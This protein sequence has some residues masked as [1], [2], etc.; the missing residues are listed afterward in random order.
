VS[1][2]TSA[3]GGLAILL[4]AVAAMSVVGLRLRS[5]LIPSAQGVLGWQL[6]AALGMLAQL[7]SAELLGLGGMLQR[8]PL[9]AVDLLLGAGALVA[10][11]LDVPRLGR[12][13]VP[14]KTVVVALGCMGVVAASW[15]L[16]VRAVAHTGI[17]AVDALDYHLVFA[18]D[19]IRSGHTAAIDYVSAGDPS[20]YYPANDELLRAVAIL[21]FGR[22]SLI[23][24][25]GLLLLPFVWGASWALGRKLGRPVEAVACSCVLLAVLGR[26]YAASAMN[27]WTGIWFLL[28]ALAVLLHDRRLGWRPLVVLGALTGLAAGTKFS[29]LAPAGV[30]ALLAVSRARSRFSSL[31]AVALGALAGGGFWYVRNWVQVGSPVPGVRALKALHLAGPEMPHLAALD[32]SVGSYLTSPH[33]MRQWFVPGLAHALGPAWW[34]IL[35]LAAGGAVVG[36]LRPAS[37][38]TRIAAALSLTWLLLYVVTPASAGG[39]VGRPVLFTFNLRFAY[40]GLLLG[41]VALT[42]SRLPALVRQLLPWLLLSVVL[43]TVGASSDSLP[44]VLVTAAGLAV[45]VVAATALR[46]R[47]PLAALL[48][49]VVL[50]LGAVGYDRVF[51]QHRYTRPDTARLALFQQAQDFHGRKIAVVGYPLKYPFFGADYDNDVRYLARHGHD[52]S[53][54]DYGRCADW[55][56]ALRSG[57]YDVVVVQPFKGEPP[58]RQLAWTSA[59]PSARTRFANSAGTIFTLDRADVAP[60]AACPP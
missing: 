43:V 9:L 20:P 5:L 27:D 39:P 42:S 11:P 54:E 50:G 26:D 55:V 18:A 37:S 46:R 16:G 15:V 10:G 49:I 8:W 33:I 47:A 7:L 12:P 38:P 29:F 44:A 25:T 41:L 1:G 17:T 45:C 56:A 30:L 21:L 2:A 6:A 57:E 51:T 13:R 48:A 28:L 34:A 24:L 4:A 60:P 23:P 22:D 32:H 52:G 31:G 58:P 3:A 35:A 19:F 59:L 53:F 14:V 36:L 40:A